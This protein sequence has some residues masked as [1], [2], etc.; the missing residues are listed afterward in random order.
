[1][2]E[3]REE[4][5]EAN[6]RPSATLGDNGGRRGRRA[7]REFDFRDCPFL[8]I[9]QMHAIK[10]ENKFHALAGFRFHVRRNPDHQ[11]DGAGL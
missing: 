1:V 7:R 9:E 4:S 3:H 8:F 11:I 2:N 5:G 6:E 10:V